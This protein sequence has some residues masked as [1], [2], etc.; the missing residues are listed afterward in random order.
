M[1][2]VRQ[3]LDEAGF[4]GRKVEQLLAENRL[5]IYTIDEYIEMLRNHPEYGEA[6]L[7]AN[8]LASYAALRQMLEQDEEIRLNIATT[9]ETIDGQRLVIE[10]W[11]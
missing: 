5:K 2:D 4:A 6:I 3:I 11:M 9:C 7:E 10:V 1:K 8:V